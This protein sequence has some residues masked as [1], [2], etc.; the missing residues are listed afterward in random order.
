MGG[1]DKNAGCNHW[2]KQG[3]CNQGHLY[4]DFVSTNCPASCG[5]CQGLYGDHF[6]RANF[7][8]DKANFKCVS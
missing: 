6:N 4:Y 7:L 5:I 2:E 3:Y 1:G 8:L